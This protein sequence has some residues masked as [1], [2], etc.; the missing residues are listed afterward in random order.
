MDEDPARLFA[1]L[2]NEFVDHQSLHGQIFVR[3]FKVAQNNIV[4]LAQLGF[5][6]KILPSLS[7]LIKAFSKAVT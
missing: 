7:M 1:E 5:E 3:V 4:K 2:C 6:I